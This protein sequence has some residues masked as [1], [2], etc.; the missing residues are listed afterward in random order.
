MF[1]THCPQ[2]QANLYQ[3]S[4]MSKGLWNIF[5]DPSVDSE[6]GRAFQEMFKDL[7]SGS[8]SVTFICYG[9]LDKSV[10]KKV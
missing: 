8:G 10:S 2:E 9:T 4:E 5:E 7:I 1:H 3:R 6:P